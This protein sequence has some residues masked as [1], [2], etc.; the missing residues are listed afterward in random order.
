MS[1][2]KIYHSLGFFF[3]IFSFYSAYELR[4]SFG[5]ESLIIFLFVILV[6]ILSDIGGY[7]FG[8][9][10]K[11]PKI[12]KISPNK[13]FSGMIGAYLFSFL[14]I[15][16]LEYTYVLFDTNLQWNSEIF[17][18]I[19]FVSTISQIGDLIVSYFK[20]LSNI[21]DTGKIIPGHGGILDRIDG[22]IFAFPL[23]YIMFKLEMLVF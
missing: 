7:I 1:K 16:F 10:F 14:I 6:C 4:N 17:I 2:S 13:T 15:Y 18:Y 8:N 21:K 20:R 3:L 5:K 22:M 9:I 23:T 11:G 12:T 19:I